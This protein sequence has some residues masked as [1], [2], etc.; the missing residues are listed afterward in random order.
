MQG[1][2]ASG[3]WWPND[4]IRF[5]SGAQGR[6][7]DLLFGPS[8]INLSVYRYNIGGGGVGVTHPG[9]DTEAFLVSPGTYDWS[10]DRGGL[11]FLRLA[12]ERRVP[13]LIGFAN[14][15]PPV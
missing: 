12:A 7:A 1:F 8:G 14:S 15:A 11:R 10:R 6:V 9:H 2:G 5:D 4:L 13:I 3:A